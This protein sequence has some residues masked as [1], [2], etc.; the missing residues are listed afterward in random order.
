[1]VTP[2][3]SP[4][5]RDPSGLDPDT[6]PDADEIHPGRA[7]VTED[8][9]LDDRLLRQRL[10]AEMFGTVEEPVSI[11]RYT[12]IEKL[13]A[14]GMG[15]VYAARD[16]ELHRTVAIKI[17]IPGVSSGAA[18][19]QREARAMAQLN[20][21]NIVTVHEVGSF[22]DQVH[23]V[24]E[25]VPGTTLRHWLEGPRTRAERLDVLL[26][27]A[28]GLAAAHEVGI[29]HRDF[30]P[31]N[32]IVGDDGRVR[33]FDFGLATSGGPLVDAGRGEGEGQAT[34]VR[35]TA[36]S[37][38]DPA[39]TQTGQR[40]GTPAYMAPEQFLASKAD[41]RSDQFSFCV[42]SYEALHGRRP[43]AGESFAELSRAVLAG[44]ILS[45]PA[46]SAAPELD[47]IV[48][49]GLARDPD[50]RNPSMAELVAALERTLARPPL[51][52]E[53]IEP[54][55][56]VVPSAGMDEVTLRLKLV[57]V[58]LGLFAMLGGVAF[59][60]RAR[61]DGGARFPLVAATALVILVL[62]VVKLVM[63]RRIG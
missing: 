28:R 31:E 57:A 3:M 45:P 24:M 38:T 12:V 32:V 34:D 2:S 7:H 16:E 50:E 60:F 5:D 37:P 47:R 30:K 39:L 1:M 29:V 40:L 22:E 33:V 46:A 14:G 20:H 48:L 59:L 9:S 18:R 6:D 58:G 17:L 19:L 26:Q 4:D 8:P 15:A 10:K 51:D 42:V 41:A 52:E 55:A 13:G 25:Y 63:K 44:Q 53:L 36:A 56:P 43:F 62:F 27:A 54:I 11:G 21:P 61:G 23:V 49:R 35:A